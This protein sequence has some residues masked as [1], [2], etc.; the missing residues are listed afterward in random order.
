MGNLNES[1]IRLAELI[2][3]TVK[4]RVS[5][6]I[7]AIVVLLVVWSSLVNG[8]E[9]AQKIDTKF[10]EYLVDNHNALQEKLTEE[11]NKAHASKPGVPMSQPLL[12]SSEN[13]CHVGSSRNWIEITRQSDEQLEG[14]PLAAPLSPVPDYVAKA[15]DEDK[16]AFA[17]Y[18]MQRHA[19]YRLQIQLSSEYSGSTIIVNAMT[20]AKIIPFCVFLVAAVV[21]ILGFQQSAYRERLHTLFQNKTGDDL[22]EARAETQFFVGSLHQNPS[23]LEKYLAVSPV[24]L[25]I[26]ALGVALILLL[27]GIVSTF[28]LNLVQLTNSVISSYPFA[29]YASLILLMGVLVITRKSYV[30]NAQPSAGRQAADSRRQPSESKWLTLTLA[31]VAGISLALPWAAS[32]LWGDGEFFRG[33]EFLLNQ[34]PTG[35][36]FNYTTYALSPTI[37]RD[38]RIQVTIAVVFLTVCASD[39]L[40]GFRPAKRLKEFLNHARGALAVCVSALSLYY[41]AYMAMLQYESVYWV[42][43]LDQLAYQG[44]TNAKGNPMIFY[45]PAYGFWIFLVCCLMLVWLSFTTETDRPGTLVRQLSGAA[46]LKWNSL[47]ESYKRKRQKST[48]RG[49]EEKRKRGVEQQPPM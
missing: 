33:F 14:I 40:V 10:C 35:H 1:E 38:V 42:P 47:V 19:A 9:E 16:K 21:F 22:A 20:I 4:L 12:L 6:L 24:D 27:T 44:P 46:T 7:L 43:W 36:L 17:E 8:N 5:L 15:N 32:S 23:R 34:R 25:A 3:R 2:W 48:S 49:D 28:L 18:D 29:L 26:G 31:L 11:I 30:Q 45:D 13:Q 39:A 41:L 37:F